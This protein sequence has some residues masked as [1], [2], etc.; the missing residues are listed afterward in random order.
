MQHL[1]LWSTHD[2]NHMP[3]RAADGSAYSFGVV[4]GT[5]RLIHELTSQE[6]Y[7]YAS[8]ES[9][10]AALQVLATQLE[11]LLWVAHKMQLAPL[12]SALH[13]LIHSNVAMSQGVLRGF[14][15]RVLTPRVQEAALGPGRTTT[16]T[17]EW[18]NSIVT[19]P[20]AVSEHQQ[21]HQGWLLQPLDNTEDFWHFE[22]RLTRRYLGM[23]AGTE[24]EVHLDLS[25]GCMHIDGTPLSMQ[26]LLGPAVL[27]EHDH[28]LLMGC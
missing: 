2:M 11:A 25:N 14:L 1:R 23:P 26:L 15:G 18:I 28:S 27:S 10:D 3:G 12:I 7:D 22:A 5:H 8:E 13:T 20:A 24:V 19:Q 6:V 9:M 16:S 4:P 21:P 17:R